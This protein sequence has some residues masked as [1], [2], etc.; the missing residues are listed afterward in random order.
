MVGP[1]GLEQALS[2]G[3]RFEGERKLLP[4]GKRWERSLVRG[5]G[6]QT[7]HLRGQLMQIEDPPNPTMINGKFVTGLDN[8]CEFPG[9]EGVREREPHDLVLHM[10]R[11]AH[12]DR[13]RATRMGQGPLIQE[14]DEARALKAPQ[15]PP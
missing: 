6:M 9:G 2:A 14:A 8:P 5:L 11:D 10:E 4:S 15:I 1:Q 7:Q 12:V 3:G 13:G